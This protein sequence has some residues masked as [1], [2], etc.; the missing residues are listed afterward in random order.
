MMEGIEQVGGGK[1]Y[2][3]ADLWSGRLGKRS[4]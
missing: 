1:S 4:I 3:T 2:E